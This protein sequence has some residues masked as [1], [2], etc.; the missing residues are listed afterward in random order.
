VKNYATREHEHP[1]AYT[2]PIFAKFITIIN[3]DSPGKI[4]FRD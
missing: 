2:L 3:D 1:D 4:T